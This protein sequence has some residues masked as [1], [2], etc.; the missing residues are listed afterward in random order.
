MNIALRAEQCC[1]NGTQLVCYQ[2]YLDDIGWS[3]YD[4]VG[5]SLRLEVG[6]PCCTISQ[7]LVGYVPQAFLDT[8]DRCMV[9]TEDRGSVCEEI[10]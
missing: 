9:H 4:T 7:L 6:H 8:V 3:S 1:R 2:T 5:Q 10:Q